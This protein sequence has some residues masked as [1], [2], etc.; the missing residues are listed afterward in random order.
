[1]SWNEVSHAPFQQV[2][3]KANCGIVPYSLAYCELY[4]TLA[5]VFAPGRFSFELYET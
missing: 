4:L 3:I 1:M 5:T 2:W